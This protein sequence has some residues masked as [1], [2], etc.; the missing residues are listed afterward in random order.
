MKLKKIIYF[1]IP[2]I[3]IVFLGVYL[4]Y[5]LSSDKY[6][7]ETEEAL[8]NAKNTYLQ[9]VVKTDT[10]RKPNII[11]I[12]ADDLGKTDISLFGNPNLQT[13][14]IDAIGKEG[15]IF[16]EAYVTSPICAPSRAGLLTGRY[17][18]RFGMEFQPQPVYPKN[19]FEY[20][21]GKYFIYGVKENAFS[22]S[23]ELE[24]PTQEQIHKQ[25]L[26]LSEITL[27][28]IFKKYHYQTAIIGKWHLGYEEPFIPLK[29][30]F[31]YQY[32]F[33]EAFSL[34]ADSAQAGI[35]NQTVDEF[36]DKFVWEKGR[37]GPHAICRNHQVIEEKEYLTDEIAK[38]AIQFIDKNKDK[39]FFLYIPFSAPHTPFQATKAYYDK[40]AHIKDP[41]QRIY[42]AM[43]HC[44]D[45]AVGSIMT[46]LKKEGL[47][48]NTIVFFASDNGGATYTKATTNDPLKGG[49]FTNLEGGLNVPMMVRWK[50]QIKAGTVFTQPVFLLDIFATATAAIN[51]QLPKDR[52]Y[53]GVDL[54]PFLKNKENTKVP[55]QYICW[56]N[57]YAKAIRKGDW[58]LII[59]DK[60][61]KK[62]LYNLKEDK[63]EKNNLISQKNSIADELFKQLQS[64][65]KE[66]KAPLWP[67]VMN[68]E[69]KVGEEV[70]YFAI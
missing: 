43:I 17:Q 34:Y 29:R 51:A 24:F 59:D 47:D 23:E 10:A 67:Y 44:L 60:T 38:E 9:E 42:F 3:I 14:N 33:Y 18:Q 8:I 32:G 57:G 35:V 69:F 36:A 5:P 64:W 37:K 61:Q 46:K 56:R 28:D 27:A 16:T 68:F 11:I 40:Y 25:G 62:Y 26:P 30:G 31:D 13:P 54:I 12:L 4:F 41:Y 1:S 58:K 48:E 49:K 63:N 20:L 39:P 15:A 45:D 2:L 21:Y 50:K 66:L 19:R 7:I 52:K 22:L 53:D 6:R 70:F 65:E 55:H